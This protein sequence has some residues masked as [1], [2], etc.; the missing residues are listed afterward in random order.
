MI[1][2]TTLLDLSAAFDII[3]HQILLTKLRL[4]FG[5]SSSCLSWFTSYLSNRTQAITVTILPSHHTPLYYGVTQGS[6]LGPVLFILYTAQTLFDYAS[7]HT[8]SHHAFADDNQLSYISTPD[9]IH[10]SIDTLQDC[11]T[12]VKSWVTAK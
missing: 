8:V 7:K 2:M 4:S 9:A 12:D 5:I 11:T 10:Q 1:R 3:N 6:V